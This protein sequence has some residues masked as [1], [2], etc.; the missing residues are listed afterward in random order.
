MF[1]NRRGF[2]AIF[3]CKQ[4]MWV[5]VWNNRFQNFDNSYPNVKRDIDCKTFIVSTININLK[6]IKTY[7]F[8]FLP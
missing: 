2:Y 5:L 6:K 1:I 4:S 3:S 7:L 8:T